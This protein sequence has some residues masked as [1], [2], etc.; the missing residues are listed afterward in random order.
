M[1]SHWTDSTDDLAGRNV[2]VV[3][4]SVSSLL[5]TPRFVLNAV[6]M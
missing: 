5:V 4:S 2:L 6:M 1:L 3:S